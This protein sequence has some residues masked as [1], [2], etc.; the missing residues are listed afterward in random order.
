[1]FA[2]LRREVRDWEDDAEIEAYLRRIMDKEAFD[3]TGLIYGMGHPVYSIS[4]PRTIVLLMVVPA[5]LLTLALLWRRRHA[6]W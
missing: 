3:R 1:M 6:C 4:D 5:L 2:E